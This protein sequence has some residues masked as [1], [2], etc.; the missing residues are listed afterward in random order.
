AEMQAGIGRGVL[1]DADPTLARLI[2]RPTTP[3]AEGIRA[4]LSA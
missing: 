2:G 3:F 4:A 1:A